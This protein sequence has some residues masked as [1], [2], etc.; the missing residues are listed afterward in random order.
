MLNIKLL[1]IKQIIGDVKNNF[2]QGPTWDLQ[3]LY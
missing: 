1:N 2:L 3:N